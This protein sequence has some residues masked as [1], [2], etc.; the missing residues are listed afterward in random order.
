MFF[1][2]AHAGVAKQDRD[3]VNGHTC[4][5]HFDGEG[6][7]EHMAVGALRGAIGIAQIGDLEEAAVAALPVGDECL[8]VSVAAPEE[9]SRVRFQ[10]IGNFPLVSRPDTDRKRAGDEPEEDTLGRQVLRPPLEAS[11]PLSSRN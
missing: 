10:A 1:C 7:A 2:D 8:G 3:L 9:V 4:Q 6:V 11:L 5:Q